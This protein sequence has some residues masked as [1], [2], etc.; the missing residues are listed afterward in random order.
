M[1]DLIPDFAIISFLIRLVY[2]LIALGAAVGFL[3]WLDWTIGLHGKFKSEVRD[4]IAKDP[5]ALAVY[6]GAR[7]AAVLWLFGQFLS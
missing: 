6:Y 1:F 5:L 4:V 2:L 3:R 7:F